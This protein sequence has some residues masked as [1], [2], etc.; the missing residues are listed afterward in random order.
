[1]K[2]LWTK[3][4]EAFFPKGL[5][6]PD[7]ALKM[8]AHTAI[9]QNRIKDANGAAVELGPPKRVVCREGEGPSV[10]RPDRIRIVIDAGCNVRE[11]ARARV[12][13]TNE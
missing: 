10:R 13:Y 8:M 6:D 7:L 2:Q 3:W 5:N 9:N 11:R 1:M 12:V 4:V